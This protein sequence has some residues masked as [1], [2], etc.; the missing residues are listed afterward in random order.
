MN[1]LCTHTCQKWLRADDRACAPADR[2]FTIARVRYVKGADGEAERDD[3]FF[4]QRYA[5]MDAALAVVRKLKTGSRYVIDQTPSMGGPA[6]S[7][8]PDQVPCEAVTK[9]SVLTP[10][11]TP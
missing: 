2:H 6:W 5:T 10:Q 8:W 11:L 1:C 3:F 4:P 7:G 9:D